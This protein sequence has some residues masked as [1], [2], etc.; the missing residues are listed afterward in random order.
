MGIIETVKAFCQL[1]AQVCHKVSR[2]VCFTES[3]H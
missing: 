2:L 1:V 3:M